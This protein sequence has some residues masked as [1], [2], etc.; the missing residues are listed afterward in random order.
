MDAYENSLKANIILFDEIY[1]TAI[2]LAQVHGIDKGLIKDVIIRLQKKYE[3]EGF[4][5]VVVPGTTK[6]TGIGKRKSKSKITWK[7]I[8][9]S[10]GY[11]YTKELTNNNYG[12]ISDDHHVVVGSIDKTGGCNE[13]TNS[14][15]V[16]L[17]G[18]SIAYKTVF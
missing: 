11:Y 3:E 14:D 5:I 1:S 2:R 4:K 9:G 10:P 16:Y 13:L 6:T 17:T 18:K 7:E 15:I 8:P 12:Y